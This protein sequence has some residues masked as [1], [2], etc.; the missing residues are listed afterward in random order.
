M[1]G[2]FV[3]RTCLVA[4]YLKVAGALQEK[5]AQISDRASVTYERL[6]G[7]VTTIW[8]AHVSHAPAL[9]RPVNDD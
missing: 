6:Y 2:Q 1:Q 3:I 5:L 9:Y 8:R 7:S 4:E